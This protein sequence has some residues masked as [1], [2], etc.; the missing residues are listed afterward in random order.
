MSKLSIFI[1]VY[2]QPDLAR[3]CLAYL[4]KQSSQDFSVILQD[5]ASQANYQELISEFP[6]LKIVLSRN[7]KNLGA[8]ANMINCLTATTDSE[9]IM[10]LH[11]DDFLHPEYLKQALNILEHNPDVAFVASPAYFFEPG[12]TVKFPE[13]INSDWEKYAPVDFVEFILNG[14]RFAFG[15]LI[16]RNAL[17]HP[18]LIDLKTYDVFFDRPFLLKILINSQKQ[19]AVLR[20]CFY[21]Y[22][23]HPYPDKRWRSVVFDNIL[24]LYAYY[25][26]LAPGKGQAITSQYL[27]DFVNLENKQRGDFQKFIT[28]GRKAGLISCRRLSG[29]F[30]GASLFIYLFGKK[31]YQRLFTLIKSRKK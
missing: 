12:E 26:S 22:Q 15:S 5:D 7:E 19:A 6:N 23:N 11:E 8:I 27:F 29:K 24:N 3:R 21:Y 9:F 25:E 17:V 16:Y 31:S 20:D 14:N 4:A 18:E 2:N 13:T 28:Q 1:P 10:C 30:L